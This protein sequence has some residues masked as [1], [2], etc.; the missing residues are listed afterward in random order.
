M[1]TSV[2][3]IVH[4]ALI[5]CCALEQ[6]FF[7]LLGEGSHGNHLILITL[8]TLSAIV[9][10]SVSLGNRVNEMSLAG[11]HKSTLKFISSFFI[12]IGDEHFPVIR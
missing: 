11:L 2:H 3:T 6:S 12:L 8:S 4:L 5:A 9:N 10:R 1:N 7:F